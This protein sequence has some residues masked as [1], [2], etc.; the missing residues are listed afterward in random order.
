MC[1]LVSLNQC[2]GAKP[3]K[4]RQLVSGLTTLCIVLME[5]NWKK[6]V[7]L[8]NPHVVFEEL[9]MKDIVQK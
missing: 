7:L 2:R 8:Q 3:A 9:R 4:K 6:I 5:E 1:I